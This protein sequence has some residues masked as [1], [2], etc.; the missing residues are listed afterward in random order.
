MSI[1]ARLE[2]ATTEF[3]KIQKDLTSAVEARQK[4]DTQLQEN[5]IVEK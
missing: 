1:E 5:E 2:S 4:L 3:Q